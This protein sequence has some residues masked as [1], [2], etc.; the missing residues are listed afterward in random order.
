MAQSPRAATSP[1]DPVEFTAN[2]ARHL[3]ANVPRYLSHLAG[4][5]LR[6]LEIG[7]F[8]GRSMRWMFEHVLTHPD[9]GAIGFDAWGWED[10]T[11]EKAE[12]NLAPYRGRIEL[13]R[14]DSSVTLREPRIEPGTID[15]AYIDGSHS[16]LS[17][18]TDSV[19]VWPLVAVGGTVIW[20][21]YGWRR[22][23]WKRSPKHERPDV[24]IDTFVMS[25]C[26][27]AELIFRNYQV[28]VRKTAT[29][30]SPFQKGVEPTSGVLAPP[31]E[32]GR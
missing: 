12:Q 14:G 11:L 31:H 10:G 8:E 6:Y 25:L 27:Q 29:P 13:V 18:L 28:A 20:D 1:D 4:Q 30:P 23:L 2:W 32:P 19:L 15:L 7:V 3:Q 21:D 26:G 5:P 16:A 24:A 22:R 9:C 17:V